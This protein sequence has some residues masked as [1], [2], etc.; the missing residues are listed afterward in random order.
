MGMSD[1]TFFDLK[2]FNESGAKFLEKISPTILSNN[3]GKSLKTPLIIFTPNAEQI[4][5]AHENPEFK[6]TLQQADYLLPDGM[7]LVWA[8]KIFSPSSEEK[9]QERIAGVDVVNQLINLAEKNNKKILVVGGR[10]L[11]EKYLQDKRII[12]VKAYV[13]KENPSAQEEKA[14]LHEIEKHQAEIVLVA[15][16]A[17]HQEKWI[18]E[19]RVFLTENNVK[20]AMA[21]GGALDFLSGKVKRAPLLM[22][23]AGMEWL[24]RLIQEPWRWRRQL[25]LIKFWYL[26][27]K[28]SF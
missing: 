2:I 22:Q 21:V 11:D 16:G 18:I 8:S 19:H 3:S 24:Y 6:K 23:K 15:L 25:R 12:W 26:V 4:V 28:K 7:S 10:D 17:P 14:L 20:I 13:D 9:I 5:Q 1:C 27:L